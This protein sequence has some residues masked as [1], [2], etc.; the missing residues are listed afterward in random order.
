MIITPAQAAEMLEASK[1]LIKWMNENCH[2]H[3]HRRAGLDQPG[4]DGFVRAFHRIREG[5][6]P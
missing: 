4:G 5:L 2:P 3:R 1:P 6:T